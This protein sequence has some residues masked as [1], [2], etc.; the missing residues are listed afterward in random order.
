MNLG[1]GGQHKIDD[2]VE[3]EEATDALRSTLSLAPCS[4]LQDSELSEVTL[5][6]FSRKVVEDPPSRGQLDPRKRSKIAD[7]EKCIKQQ[8]VPYEDIVGALLRFEFFCDDHVT[9]I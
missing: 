4:S 3:S 9:F 1:I 5:R 6:P 7:L 8:Q 2:F